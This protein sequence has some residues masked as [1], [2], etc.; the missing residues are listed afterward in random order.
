MVTWME[1]WEDGRMGGWMS[2]R[3]WKEECIPGD[4]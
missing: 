2:R 3:S 4:A 1:G